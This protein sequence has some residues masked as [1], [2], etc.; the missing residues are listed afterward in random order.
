M[1]VDSH[2]HIDGPEYDADRDDVVRRAR[3]AGVSAILNV[4]AGVPGTGIFERAITVAERYGG[5]FAAVGVHPHEARLFDQQTYDLLENVLGSRKRL[6]ALGEIGLDFHYD[7]SP[8]DV[9]R[10]VFSRQLSLARSRG[11][12]VIVHSREADVETV[13]ILRVEFSAA[14][15]R[16]IM[17][18]FG[19]GE[20]MARDVLDL[21]FMISFA[22]NIT[23]KNAENLRHVARDV[24]LDRLLVETDCPYLTPVPYRGRRNEP[25]RVREVAHSLA[26][27]RGLSPDEMGRITSDNFF[28]FFSLEREAGGDAVPAGSIPAG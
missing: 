7:H 5:V 1:Y 25:A 8:R 22:G 27:I 13:N 23:F 20:A 12:P 3:E 14:E 19:G 4:C 24:P 11:V 9:Q 10:E 15:P 18:C 2:A 6:I 28:R 16:G 26:E 21:G 17:H